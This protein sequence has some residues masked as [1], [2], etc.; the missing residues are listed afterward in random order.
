MGLKTYKIKYINSS[1]CDM[2]EIKRYILEKF[3]YR[4]FGENYTRKMKKAVDTLKIMSTGF[5]MIGIKYRG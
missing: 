4:E 1:R 2:Q 3:K 5:D